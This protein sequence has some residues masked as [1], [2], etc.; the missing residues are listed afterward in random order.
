MQRSS[1]S[2]SDLASLLS[3]V[4]VCLIGG[5]ERILEYVDE[6]SGKLDVGSEDVAVWRELT[7]SH[8]HIPNDFGY[9]DKRT[10]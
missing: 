7:E 1:K 2:D 5:H 9:V 3:C 8:R 4:R 6:I 10:T